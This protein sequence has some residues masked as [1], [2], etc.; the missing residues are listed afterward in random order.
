MSVTISNTQ[1]PRI[2][3]VNVTATPLLTF[4]NWW[5]ASAWVTVTEDGMAVPGAK[6]EGVWS[7]LYNKKASNTTDSFGFI[8]FETGWLRTPGTVTFTVTR[9]IAP[10]GEEYVLD[11]SEPSG[12]TT[13]P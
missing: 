7:S 13:G 8:S 4:R 5:V 12:T 3:Q 6:I 11:P 2:A 10:D 1:V 9:V